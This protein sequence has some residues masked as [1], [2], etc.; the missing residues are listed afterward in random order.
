MPITRRQAIDF[1]KEALEASPTRKIIKQLRPCA[2]IVLDD[3]PMSVIDPAGSYLGGVPCLPQGEGWPRWDHRAS[4]RKMLD[5]TRAKLE[6]GPESR[7]QK[8]LLEEQLAEAEKRLNLGSVPLSFLCQVNLEQVQR[9]CDLP[10]LPKSGLMQCYYEV[11]KDLWPLDPTDPGGFRVLYYPPGTVLSPVDPP[12]ELETEHCYDAR[13]VTFS[14]FWSLPHWFADACLV[15][16]EDDEAEYYSYIDLIYDLEFEDAD[17]PDHAGQ[18][19]GWSRLLQGDLLTECQLAS[20]GI[21]PI[22]R[23]AD[24]LDPRVKTLSRGAPDW[25]PMV[26]LESVSEMG[27][28]WGDAGHLTFLARQDESQCGDTSG[29]WAAMQS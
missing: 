8:E 24:H 25:H 11:T 16:E 2:G 13:A 20:N 19:G 5:Q 7:Y 29:A 17:E 9:V 21:D 22:E 10:N 15:R 12:D 14:L 6:A 4:Y 18:I 28:C 3:A 23:Y 1:I 27:W 26:M